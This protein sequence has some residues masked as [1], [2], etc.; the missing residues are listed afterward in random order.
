[1]RY[2]PPTDRYPVTVDRKTFTDQMLLG[3]YLETKYSLRTAQDIT[4]CN[5]CHR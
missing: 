4:S 1:M 3:K 2:Q 5:T